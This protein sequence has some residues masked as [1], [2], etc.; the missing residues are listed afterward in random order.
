MSSSSADNSTSNISP[1]T[2]DEKSYNKGDV[3]ITDLQIRKKYNGKQWRRLCSYENC[4]KESQR[5]G[6]CSR[7][8][9]LKDKQDNSIISLLNT[10]NYQSPST[11]PIPPS[12]QQQSSLPKLF[13]E[14][15]IR[16]PINSFM[17][18]S[19]EERGK[20]HLEN[21]HRDNRNVSK[22]LGENW[23]SLSHDQQQEY[24]TRAKQINEQL[25]RSARL[26][27]TNKN[28][29]SPPPDPLQAFAQVFKQF[30]VFNNKIVSF[31]YIDLYK[32][33]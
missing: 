24:K 19:Q 15:S 5:F 1:N 17:L 32:Y 20:I 16:R 28:P 10:N 33:A 8:L 6:F 12:E 21:P 31:Y 11:T 4:T 23:Y 18:F 29:T 7:H 13:K 2:S 27:S 22:I 9:S 14:K 30:I 3:I 26:Q 25:R